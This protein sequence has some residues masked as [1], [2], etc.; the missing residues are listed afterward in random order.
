[1]PSE[2]IDH[3]TLA[4]LVQ[5]GTVTDA[6]IVGRSGGWG[7]MVRYG[8]VRRM[9]ATQ[10]SHDARTFRRFE[11]LVAYLKDIGISRFEVDAAHFQ[12]VNAS[13]SRR[14]D[15]SARLKHAHDAAVHDQWFRGEVD[16][17]LAE[18]NDAGTAWISNDEAKRRAAKRRAALARRAGKG[19]EV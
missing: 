2:T 12:P 10:R 15:V 5:S 17:A 9:L 19:K 7:V 3:A 18:A 11:T 6:E 4:D 14:A 13:S 8:R 16:R 1:M